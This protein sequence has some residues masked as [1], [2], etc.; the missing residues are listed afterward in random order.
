MPTVQAYE[1]GLT[2]GWAGGREPCQRG[3]VVYL[4]PGCCHREGCECLTGSRVLCC[5]HAPAKRG[6]VTG[7]SAGTVRRHTAWLRSVD[8]T[9]L[10]GIGAAVTL[11]LLDCPPTS[12]DWTRLVKVLQQRLRRAGLLRWHWVV[13]W[14][15]RGVP[16]LHLAVYAAAEPPTCNTGVGFESRH[17]EGCNPTPPFPRLADSP[18]TDTGT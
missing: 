18:I 4:G 2:L 14:Q 7:W 5:A 6:E 13:E 11:T 8:T 16:H 3:S 15:R 9:Q 17:P 1:N 12:E 10:D